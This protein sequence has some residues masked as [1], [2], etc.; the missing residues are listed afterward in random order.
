MKKLRLALLSLATLASS[1]TAF[2]QNGS[3]WNLIPWAP[4]NGS[5]VE[6]QRKVHLEKNGD[7]DNQDWLDQ[8]KIY[9]FNGLTS[10]STVQ[11]TYEYRKPLLTEIFR[12]YGSASRSVNRSEI[13][14]PDY[15]AAQGRQ[16]EAYVELND[17]LS[18][19]QAF[20]Q[21]WGYET[22]SAGGATYLQLRLSSSGGIV[23]FGGAPINELITGINFKN[24]E[25]KLNVIHIQETRSG[26]TVT[27]PGY[28]QIYVNGR[29]H[30]SIRDTWVTRARPGRIAQGDNYF[31]YGVYGDVGVGDAQGIFKEARYFQSG[32]VPGSTPQTIQ[33]NPPASVSLGGGDVTLPATSSSNLGVVFRSDNL[34]VAMIVGG[35]LRPLATGTVKIWAS[36]GGNSTYQPA[37]VVVREITVAPGGPVQQAQTI[38]FPAISNKLTTDAPFVLNATASSGLAV[39]YASNN[40]AVATVSGNTVTIVGAGS[41]NITA[42]QAGNASYLPATPVTR[43]FTVTAPVTQQP[44]TITFPPIGQKLVTDP[45]FNPGATASSG[46]AV[47]YTSSNPAIATI[48]GGLVDIVGAGTV[49]ITAKQAGNA[50]Y[51]PATDVAQTFTVKTPVTYHK[52]KLRAVQTLVLNHTSTPANGGVVNVATDTGS[53]NQLWKVIPTTNGYVRIAPYANQAFALDCSAVAPVNGSIIQLWTYDSANTNLRQQWLRSTIS[54]TTAEKVTLRATSTAGTLVLDCKD[55]APISG[56]VVQTWTYTAG[57][58]NQRQQ[59]IFEPVVK[60]E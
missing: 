5:P 21:I 1:L 44:Q 33:F 60:I 43:T 4:T 57:D 49:T 24:N 58:T 22:E 34:A 9:Y 38:T 2:G 10:P 16:F 30:G 52:I 12:H 23:F 14:L 39:S 19:D 29:L 27:T 13:R 11:G 31:K 3:G 15:G 42:S 20:F 54:G 40:T 46:L 51:L 37:P 25:F 48:V 35:K 47:T 56:S 6:G 50:S 41:V 45:N 53:N 17:K 55:I 18:T 36:Q 26:S 28:L 7:T 8:S 32:S 59:W